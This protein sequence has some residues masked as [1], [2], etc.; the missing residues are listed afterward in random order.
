[1]SDKLLDTD[2]NL[3]IA[4]EICIEHYHHGINAPTIRSWLNILNIPYKDVVRG[5]KSWQYIEKQYV[6][7][8]RE[9]ITKSKTD[10][11]KFTCIK[12]YGVDNPSKVDSIKELK[13]QT[14]QEHYGV[15]NPFQSEEVKKQIVE[16]NR[17]NLGVDYPRQSKE[18]IQKGRETYLKKYGVINNSC[19]PEEKEQRRQHM[20]KLNEKSKMSKKYYDYDNTLFD[21]SWELYYYIYQKDILHNKI[22]RG[23]RFKYVDKEGIEHT[24]VCDFLVN[25]HENVEIKGD[26]LMTESGILKT[27]STWEE[28]R[29]KTY[30]MINNNVTVL[31]GEQIYPIIKEVE[32]K[33][34]G[35]VESCKRKEKRK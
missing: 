14:T 18:V 16:V 32:T 29:E 22:S 3:I 28:N 4:D 6:P 30:C 11:A 27:F 33:F 21:S 17:K 10:K 23:K 24:Y 12:L 26:H 5:R 35:L 8:F 20:I 34:P 1:M 2:P 19:L 13:R 31:R 7:K 9:F 25:G 15:D